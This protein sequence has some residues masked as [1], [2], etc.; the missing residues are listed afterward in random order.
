MND[1]SPRLSR[2]AA[3]L[4]NSA[5]VL[6]A[7]NLVPLAGAVFLHWTVFEIVILFWAENVII[8]ALNVPRMLMASGGKLVNGLSKVFMIPFLIFHYGMF[9]F[10]HGV[11]VFT[12]FGGE[13][14][15]SA[16]FPNDIEPMLNSVLDLGLGISLI[17]LFLSHA[18]S[19]FWNYVAKGEYLKADSK[20]MMVRPYG[21]IFVLHVT[22][23]VG[24]FF[25]LSLGS[26]IAGLILLVLLKLVFDLRAHLKEHKEKLKPAIEDK[27][28]FNQILAQ[29]KAAKRGAQRVPVKS[30]SRESD[31]EA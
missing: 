24:G 20:S 30:A 6:I 1:N 29:L 19:F 28:T 18:F 17:A 23:I 12:L 13:E 11:F 26:P 31:L 2:R 8:G 25:L 15:Q 14:L 10:V 16:R 7:A 4:A 3:L 5:I 9:T 22:I 21:R 27:P